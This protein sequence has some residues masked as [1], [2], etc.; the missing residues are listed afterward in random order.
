MVASGLRRSRAGPAMQPIADWL[1]KLGLGQYTQCFAENDI[2]FSIL[3]DLT[4][5]DL[6]DLGVASLG[7]RRQLLRA[8]AQPG[9]GVTTAIVSAIKPPPPRLRRPSTVR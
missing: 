1:R 6:K 3:P 7:H 4:D 5:Q 8:I 9:G 2:N